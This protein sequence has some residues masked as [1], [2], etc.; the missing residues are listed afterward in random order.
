MYS[1]LAETNPQI[2]GWE[3]LTYLAVF[4]VFMVASLVI[5]KIYAKSTKVQDIIVRCTGLLL[6]IFI[7]WN[8]IAICISHQRATYIIPDSFC[9]MSSL[10]LALAVIFGKRNNN[11]LH[12]VFYFAILGDVLSVFYPDFIGQASS[13]FYSNTIS[14]LLHHSFGLLLCILLCLVGWFSPNYKKSGNIVI[15]FMAYIT[16]GAFLMSVFDYSDAF[17]INHPI[18]SG[19]PLTVWVLI[20]IFV[21]L[22]TLFMVIY[23]LVRRKLQKKNDSFTKIK[24]VLN[25]KF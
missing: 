21:A 4:L 1:M 16:V 3:H 15:G 2:F 14:G 11:V 22:Y 23:E 24:K 9:G 7:L 19:T 18:L 10:V 17:Y 8:R 5:I 6:F 12:F 13:I 20:P 25:E